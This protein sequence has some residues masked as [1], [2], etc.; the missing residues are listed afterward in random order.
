MYM[1][2]VFLR[3]INIE[4]HTYKKNKTKQKN[5]CHTTNKN[6]ESQRTQEGQPASGPADANHQTLQTTE[7]TY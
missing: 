6:T 1:L 2:C 4:K 7:Q 3:K 5:P